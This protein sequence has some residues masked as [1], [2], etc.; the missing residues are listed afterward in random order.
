M[1]PTEAMAVIR[2]AIEAEAPPEARSVVQA[3]FILAADTLA[4]LKGLRVAL[5]RIAAAAEKR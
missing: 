2:A 3:G 1:T 5:E 4:D